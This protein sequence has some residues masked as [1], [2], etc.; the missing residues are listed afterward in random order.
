MVKIFGEE[1]KRRANVIVLNE[2]SSHGD[3][4]D[5]LDY[6]S[7]CGAKKIFCVHGDEKQIEQ[8]EQGLRELGQKEIFV[9]ERGNIFEL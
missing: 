2:F 9:P 8:L 1:Y 3:R 4:R 7:G 5:L 6:A